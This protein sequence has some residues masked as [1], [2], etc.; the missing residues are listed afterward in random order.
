MAR[1]RYT[2]EFRASTVIML[3][4]AGYPD[5][6]GALQEVSNHVGVASMTIS[7]WFHASNNPPPNE[8]VS[9]Q[10]EDIVRLMIGEVHAAVIEMAKA[11]QDADYK[12][13]ATAA[14]ILTDKWQLL[15]GKPTERTAHVSELSDDE[16][17]Q[18]IA[19]LFDRA[20][21]RQAGLSAT[22]D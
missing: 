10:K 19:A 5:K 3:Q 14:A 12:D 21:A 20:R 15:D 1:R 7:R 18:G 4:A 13:L 11:R 22:D 16:R 9:I 2:D 17:S 6:K 8:L